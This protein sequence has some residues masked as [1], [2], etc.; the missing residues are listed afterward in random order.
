MTNAADWV[1]VPAAGGGIQGVASSSKRAPLKTGH[2]DDV[3]EDFGDASSYADW[4]FT[5]TPF[6]AP[7]TTAPS[8][9]SPSTTHPSPR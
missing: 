5:F 2:F 6:V 7:R 1:L 8:T 3:D 4:K 9:T